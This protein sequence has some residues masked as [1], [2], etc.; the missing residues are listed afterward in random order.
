MMQRHESLARQLPPGPDIVSHDGIA[1][2]K[3]VLVP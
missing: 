1:A 3:P 2:G